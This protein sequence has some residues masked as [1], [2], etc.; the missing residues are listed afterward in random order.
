[1]MTPQQLKEKSGRL[2]REGKTQEYFDLKDKYFDEAM[3]EQKKLP[4]GICVGKVFRIQVADG[5]AWY[6]VTKVTKRRAHII[7]RQDLGYDGW[8]DYYLGDGGSFDKDRIASFIERD[9]A[10]AKLFSGGK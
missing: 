4:E 5:Y 10:I 6:E 9:E 8:T 7:N 2:L 3:A 1:M